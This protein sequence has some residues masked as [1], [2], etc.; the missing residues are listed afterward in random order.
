[1]KTSLGALL[2]AFGTMAVLATWARAGDQATQAAGA[3]FAAAADLKWNDV[4]GMQGLRMAV[5][6]GDP[7]AGPSHYFI[8][9]TPGFAAPVHHHSADHNGVVLA[10][11]LVLTADG[12]EHKL[13]AGSFFSFANMTKHSTACEAG[14]ECVLA[15]DA[16]G[17]WDVVPEAEKPASKK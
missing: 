16:R 8:K 9:F 14:A 5:V 6:D 11:T 10:G 7:G 17:K 3:A 15:I 12:K 4:P 1:M 13:P 2:V